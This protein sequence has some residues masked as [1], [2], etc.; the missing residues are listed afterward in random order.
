MFHPK[1][2]RKGTQGSHE[3]TR[4]SS[5]ATPLSDPCMLLG[6]PNFT[7]P[8]APFVGK[9]ENYFEICWEKNLYATT[10]CYAFALGL[11]NPDIS[12]T[13]YH[14][15]F[16]SGIVQVSDVP[17]TADG[18]LKAVS[19]DLNRLRRSVLEVH[20]A[21]TEELPRTLQY[22][23][24]D[25]S[26]WVKLMQ[27]ENDPRNWHFAMLDP[28]SGRW[29]HKMG[30]GSP[31]KPLYHQA[32]FKTNTEI[33]MSQ[34][35]PGSFEEELTKQVLAFASGTDSLIPMTYYLEDDD[36]AGFTSLYRNTNIVH[37]KAVWVI[38]VS[39]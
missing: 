8:T 24:A 7:E 12:K 31:P 18:L 36:S 15:G 5:T 4:H 1:K 22:H 6:I 39:A 14:P 35:Q 27:A 20:R 11:T 37:Y 30:Y 10:N 16:I 26:Y 13:S 32:D 2:L 28:N 33:V 17:T 21:D 25:G 34:C 38:R 3:R 19:S 23:Y 29:L 9:D